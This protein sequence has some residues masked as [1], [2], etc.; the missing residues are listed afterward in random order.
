MAQLIDGKSTSQRIKQSLATQ[1][2]KFVSETGIRPGL[3]TI[4]VGDNSASQVY[5]KNKIKS[6]EQCG[7]RSVHHQLDANTSE[8]SLLRLIDKMNHDPFV[9]GILVQLPLPPHINSDTVLRAIDPQKDVDG[10]HP[11]NVGLL[12]TGQAVLQPCTP[13]GV[14]VLLKE[15]GISVSGQNVVI[16]GRSNIVGKP[17]A[18]M[19][20]QENATVTI[21][22]SKT[23]NLP[24][25]VR[26]ADIVV[27]AVGRARM[28]PGD[29]IKAGAVVIDVGI[30]RLEDGTLCGDVDFTSAEAKASYI[31]PVPG[32]VGPMTIAMLM[33]NTLEAAKLQNKAPK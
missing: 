15:Y 24:D 23:K 27:A 3:A 13:L 1:V 9:H 2:E 26:Q 29:W 18:L 21:A 32:G 8:E 30:N 19:M 33:Q 4:L 12:V 22:H 11:Y 17:Q 20:L 5:I 25:I 31:T 10:F 16:I 6:T 14:M 7:M 28:I